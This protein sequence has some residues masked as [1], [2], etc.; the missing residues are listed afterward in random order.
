MSRY[1]DR[2]GR[3]IR[4]PLAH[5]GVPAMTSRAQAFDDLVLDVAR[6]Y[7]AVLGRRWSQVEF[8]VE[9]VP[10]SDP[11]SWE[12]GVPLARLWPSRGRLPARI[13]VYRRPILTAAR[14]RNH[15]VIVHDVLVEQIALLLGVAPW[16]IDP[17]RP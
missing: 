11:A 17:H 6:R 13:V 3:G 1:R 9:E 5:P 4:G 12:D 16:E 8:A 10:P 2:R 15:A 14:G 7:E